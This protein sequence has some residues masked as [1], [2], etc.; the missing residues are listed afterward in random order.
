ME[1]ATYLLLISLWHG[2]KRRQALCVGRQASSANFVGCSR[3]A[4]DTC[5]V[6]T[7]LGRSF[8][9][10]RAYA[11]GYLYVVPS[12]LGLNHQHPNSIILS[13]PWQRAE[14]RRRVSHWQKPKPDAWSPFLLVSVARKRRL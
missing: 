9:L 11:L 12:G 7:G 14:D 2:E 13:G 6:L 4:R 3:G 5:A 8:P 10:P 1:Q